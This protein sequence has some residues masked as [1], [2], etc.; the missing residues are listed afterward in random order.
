[1]LMKG[2]HHPENAG[3]QRGHHEEGRKERRRPFPTGRLHFWFHFPPY[4]FLYVNLVASR[5][6]TAVHASLNA[7]SLLV[8]L[9]LIHI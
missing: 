3:A 7:A 1:M 2:R 6:P 9:L 4:L 8:F 5:T